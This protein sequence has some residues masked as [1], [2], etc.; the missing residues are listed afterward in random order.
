[1]VLGGVKALRSSGGFGQRAVFAFV[2]FATCGCIVADPP[3]FEA[4]RR[5]PP[6]LDLNRADPSVQVVKNVFFGAPQTLAVPVR[7]E[8]AGDRLIWRLYRD[9]GG[10]T[11]GQFIF[12]D[13]FRQFGAF[14]PPRLIRV[15]WNLGEPLGCQRITLVVSHESSFVPDASGTGKG[16]YTNLDDIALATWLFQVQQD[17]TNPNQ[18]LKQVDDC[19]AFEALR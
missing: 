16:T 13:Y 9:Y 11:P 7:A 6:F 12:G 2:A 8:D 14:E 3:T 19:P 10:S 17:P 1:V 4:D 18:N 15:T 5:T